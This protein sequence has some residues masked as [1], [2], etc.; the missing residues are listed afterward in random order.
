M[1]WILLSLAILFEIIATTLMKVSSGFTKLLPTLGTAVGYILCF[2][3]LSMALKKID[4][5]VAYAI[6]GAAGITIM[7]AI[8]ILFFKESINFLKVASI[9]FIVLGVIGLNLSGAKH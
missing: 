8:G 9:L 1:H 6:W 4:L 7:A 3:F 5:S 2:T